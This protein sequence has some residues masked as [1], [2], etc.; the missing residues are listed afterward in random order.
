M[1]GLTYAEQREVLAAFALI[2]KADAEQTITPVSPGK[3]N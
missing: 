2:S 1:Y 3:A